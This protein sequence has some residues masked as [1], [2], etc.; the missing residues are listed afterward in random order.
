MR[1]ISAG[2]PSGVSAGMASIILALLVALAWSSGAPAQEFPSRTVRFVVP[3][4]AGGSGDLLARLLGNKLSAMWGQ[5][6][7]VDNKPG[8]GGLIG[9]EIAAHAAPDGHTLYLATDGPL[10]IAA[11]LHKFVPYDWKRDFAP[12]SMIAVGPQILIVNPQLPAKT[13]AE[14]IALAKRKP[15]ALNY[16]SIGIGTAPHLAAELFKSVAQVDLTHVPYKGSSAQAITALIAGDVA[17]F[18]VGTSTAIGQ[19]QA[20]RLR[21]LAVTSPR[22]VEGLP[23]V[24]T[25]AESGLPG[26]DVSLWFAVL[27]PSA[28]PQG[29]VQRLHADI[30]KIVASPEYSM[31]LRKR[32]FD[33]VANTPDELAAFLEKDYLK[34][35]ALIQKLGLQVE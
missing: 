4:A 26:V 14:F 18:M 31:E 22:R 13:L 21:G 32:G 5:Q 8:A 20:G 11:S 27:V 29:V 35:R 7:I 1:R 30:A 28:T 23:D 10:T 25:F 34:Y 2:I 6:V 16:A 3:Y 15:G 24:P 12:V 9:T 33:A 19:V 17:M